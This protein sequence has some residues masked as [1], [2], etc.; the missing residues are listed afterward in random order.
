MSKS[1]RLSTAM[2]IL[3]FI[4]VSDQERITSQDIADSLVTNASYVRQMMSTLKKEGFILSQQGAARPKLAKEPEDINLLEIYHIIEPDHHLLNIA[5]DVNPSCDVAECVQT[6]LQDY[7]A[8][9]QSDAEKQMEKIT[10]ADLIIPVKD[11]IT[12][13]E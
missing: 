11:P 2:H 7:Y 5:S 10:L 9:I 6:N 8:N 3:G 13:Q 1:Y 4:Y 12:V